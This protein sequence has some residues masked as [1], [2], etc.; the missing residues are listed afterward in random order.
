MK[1]SEKAN[2]IDYLVTVQVVLA[3]SAVQERKKD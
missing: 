1:K 2:N 3:H